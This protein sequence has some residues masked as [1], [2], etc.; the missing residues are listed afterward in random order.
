MQARRMDS[1][2]IISL[3]VLKHNITISFRCWSHCQGY[4]QP[5]VWTLPQDSGAINLRGEEGGEAAAGLLHIGRSSLKPQEVAARV[6]N[7][8]VTRGSQKWQRKRG[9]QMFVYTGEKEIFSQRGVQIHYH[10]P[11][12]GS[13]TKTTN[14]GLYVITKSRVSMTNSRLML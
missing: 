6:D 10:A 9:N 5:V 13:S 8:V 7:E 11:P 12:A 14:R 2:S 3:V 4:E 1:L